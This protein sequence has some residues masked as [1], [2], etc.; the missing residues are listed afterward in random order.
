MMLDICDANTAAL[1]ASLDAYIETLR[2]LRARIANGD[3]TL[4]ETFASAQRMR[5]GW[6][7]ARQPSE[8]SLT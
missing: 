4:E 8:E 3:A 2:L 1:L 6:L 5:D 7:R